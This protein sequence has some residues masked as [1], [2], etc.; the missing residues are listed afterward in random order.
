MSI[1]LGYGEGIILTT[2]DAYWTSRNNVGLDE[3]VLTNKRVYCS[4]KRSN[5]L[6]KKPTVEEYEFYLGDIIITNGRAFVQQTRYEGVQCL[7]IQFAQ[8]SEFFTFGSAPRRV[9]PQWVTAINNV[10]GTASIADA[11]KSGR[12]QS[13]FGG[14][15]SGIADTFMNAIDSATTTNTSRPSTLRDK[16]NMANNRMDYDA[17]PVRRVEPVTS[18]TQSVSA[19]R[20]SKFCTNCG[21]PISDGA[22]FCSACGTP[23]GVVN[24]S[25]IEVTPSNPNTGKASATHVEITRET[26]TERHHEYVGKVYKCPNCG[27][28]VNISD[29]ICEACGFHLSGKIAIH[30]ARDFQEQLMRVETKRQNVKH[31]FWDQREV[32]DATD[33]EIISLIKT[34]PIPNSIEDIIEFFHLAVAN[35][36]V[37]KSKKS[38]FNTDGW[39]GGDRE[40]AISNA[41]VGKLQSIYAKAELYFPN[42]PEFAKVKEVYDSLMVQLKIK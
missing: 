32:L 25:P 22:K 20:G 10:L 38:V 15:F 6:F 33:K 29:A 37:N 17:Q 36:D 26:Y 18:N 34:Y 9:I 7:Q 1:N 42:E 14:A 28:T 27:N 30:S 24:N 5:G 21:A 8:G 11:E 23:V 16:A 40:R 2:E 19:G 4:Y 13:L 35:I 41:W 31:D 39:D 3:L 12:K